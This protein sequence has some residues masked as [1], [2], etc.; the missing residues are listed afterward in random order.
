MA[1]VA[2]RRRR[3]PSATPL[4]LLGVSV[5]IWQVG[6]AL[7]LGTDG[8]DEM[9]FWAKIQYIGITA[10]PTCWLAITLQYTGRGIRLS[11][12]NIALLAVVPGATVVLAATNGA[13]ELIWSSIT[14]EPS[15]SLTVLILEHGAGFWVHA[16]YSYLL[17]LFGFI[18]LAENL[19]QPHRLYWEQAAA[20]MLAALLP[21][22][23]NWLFIAGVTPGNNIDLTPLAF[24]GSVFVLVWALARTQLLDLAPVARDLVFGNMLD[25]VLVLDTR[26]RVVDCNSAAEG[27]VGRPADDLIGRPIEDVWQA[28]S[29]LVDR[30][31]DQSPKPLRYNVGEG[32]AQYIYDVSASPIRDRHQRSAGRLVFF[33]DI[34]R[35]W[36]EEERLKETSRLASIGEMA[37]GVAHEIN[38]PLMIIAGNSEMLVNQGIP[39]LVKERVEVIHSQADRA[40]KIVRNLLAFVRRQDSEKRFLDVRTVVE[41]TLDLKAYDLSVGNIRVLWNWPGDLPQ[42]MVDEHQ[43]AQVIM[44][45]VTNAEQAMIKSNGGGEIT[46]GAT[47]D[48]GNIRISIGD[49]GPGIP[50]D[51]MPRIFEPFFTTK[52][53]GEGTGLGLSICY[54]IVHQHGG[55]ICVESTLGEGATF[56]ISLPVVG[57]MGVP[58]TGRRELP[59]PSTVGMNLLVVDDEAGIRDL[60]SET[61]QEQGYSVDEAVDGESAWAMVQDKSYDCVLL[62]LRMPGL[63][64]QQLF[65]LIHDY[66]VEIANRIIFLTGDILN[67][68][69]KDFIAGLGNP[70]L[71][72]PFTLTDLR[73]C[74]REFLTARG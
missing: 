35:L 11:R 29:E 43:L 9:V 6:Y 12:R 64:G 16:G 66:D 68:H 20:L 44:N 52:P 8:Q 45:I 58:E 48:Q 54:G 47:L 60:Y 62:D 63:N 15:G 7:E 32:D 10:A 39:P 72:K 3:S 26:G 57:T 13:H 70:V 23:A 56:H 73:N 1:G 37:S 5:A 18:L 50:D 67:P 22:I 27:I 36:L 69:V 55:D 61:L 41:Q 31:L 42:T 71:V 33:H 24:I 38:N 34:T 46:V 51:D 21:W 19:L 49:T 4:V 74:V 25:G 17:L 40:A 28:G 2:W 65:D 59:K 30:T 14:S 53:V